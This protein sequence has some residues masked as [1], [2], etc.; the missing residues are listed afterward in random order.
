MYGIWTTLGTWCSLVSCAV[1]ELFSCL[2]RL[3]L[4][5]QGIAWLPVCQGSLPQFQLEPSHH[6]IQ[7][8][9]LF[10]VMSETQI[11]QEGLELS[12]RL[13]SLAKIS[14]EDLLLIFLTGE[15]NPQAPS[16]GPVVLAGVIPCV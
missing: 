16:A 14:T 5:T 15:G 11:L 1:P 12:K 6:S 13:C 3:S 10:L 9:N 4:H 2:L 8:K 7:Q